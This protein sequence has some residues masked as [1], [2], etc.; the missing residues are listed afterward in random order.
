[1]YVHTE[2]ALCCRVFLRTKKKRSVFDTT[3]RAE[4]ITEL[5]LERAS[6]VIFETFLLEF[7]TFRLIPVICP[8]RGA[9]PENHWKRQLIPDRAY[10]A[11]KSVKFRNLF[12]IRFFRIRYNFGLDKVRLFRGALQRAAGF[13]GGSV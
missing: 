13:V 12:L 4:I 7:I 3:V 1:M 2:N 10:P 9:D 6:P 5:I 8:A 11:I